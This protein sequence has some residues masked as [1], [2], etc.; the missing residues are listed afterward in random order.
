MG[1]PTKLKKFTTIRLKSSQIL[2]PQKDIPSRN[3]ALGKNAE[4]NYKMNTNKVILR[5][6]LSN[7]F[8]YS[9]TINC[10]NS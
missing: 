5:N 4:S 3:K 2:V 10:D 6:N 9:P 7:T 8:S 1:S